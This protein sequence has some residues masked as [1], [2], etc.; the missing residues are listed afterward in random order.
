MDSHY[1][2]RLLSH[3]KKTRLFQIVRFDAAP[4]EYT[5]NT[6]QPRK[7]W[8]GPESDRSRNNPEQASP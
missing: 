5:G 7:G 6:D 4:S 8:H 3:M 1:R 2:E